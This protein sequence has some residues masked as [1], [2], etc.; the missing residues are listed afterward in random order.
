MSKKISS[1]FREKKSHLSGLKGVEKV[2]RENSPYKSFAA[3]ECS[4]RERLLLLLKG[5]RQ[6]YI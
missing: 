3:G 2:K 4:L 6:L 1:L 5:K